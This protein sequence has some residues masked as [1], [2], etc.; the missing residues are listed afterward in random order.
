MWRRFLT[1]SSRIT[2]FCLGG[3]RRH[4]W[5]AAL[6]PVESRNH[7]SRDTLDA[8]SLW[9]VDDGSP[10]WAY[11]RC[12]CGCGEIVMLNLLAG[13]RPRWSLSRDLLDRAS[14]RPS[15]WRLDGCRSHFWVTRGEI[16]WCSQPNGTDSLCS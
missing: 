11:L 2:Q 4:W 8:R 15:V 14:L 16:R 5:P 9:L 1:A 10:K 6:E 7:P 13:S 3:I 12:P